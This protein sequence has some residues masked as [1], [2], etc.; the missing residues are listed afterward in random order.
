[1][2]PSQEESKN[3]PRFNKFALS[4][5][6]SEVDEYRLDLL[7][8]SENIRDLENLDME[9][10]MSHVQKA[11]QNINKRHVLEALN[12]FNSLKNKPKVKHHQIQLIVIITL[13]VTDIIL[14]FHSKITTLLTSVINFLIEYGGLIALILVI[15]AMLGRYLQKRKI[16]KINKGY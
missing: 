10:N 1:M 13:L 2:P 12:E 5:V 4:L 6:E 15:L 11:K 7:I 9:I 16:E 3:K 8:K 14:K